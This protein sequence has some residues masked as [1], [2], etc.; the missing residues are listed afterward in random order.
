[1]SMFSGKCDFYDG[2]VAINCDGDEETVEKNLKDLDL[3]VY[4][5]DMRKHKV[6][7]NTIKDIAKY[8]PYLEV[9]ATYSRDN[10]QTII[11]SSDSFIDQEEREHLQWY[12]DDVMK[13]WRKCKRDKKPFNVDECVEKLHWMNTDIIK[14][15]AERVAKDGVKAE[16]EDIHLPLHEYF[17]RRWFDELVRIGYTERQA[18]DW[19]FKGFFT[20]NEIITK[21]LGRPLNEIQSGETE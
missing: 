21:R 10:G 4:G 3:Y 17:R 9:I 2:F 19:C 8:Y 18:Y 12:I 7:S 16:F 20:D 13:Y 14:T 11:L 6:E 15:I 1:M 5:R